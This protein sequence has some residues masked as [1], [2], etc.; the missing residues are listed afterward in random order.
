MAEYTGNGAKIKIQINSLPIR[1]SENIPVHSTP[2]ANYMKIFDKLPDDDLNIQELPIFLQTFRLTESTLAV[3]NPYYTF[4]CLDDNQELKFEFKL[5]IQ[6]WNTFGK[7]M[8]YYDSGGTVSSDPNITGTEGGSCNYENQPLTEL[9]N[10]LCDLDDI[11]STTDNSRC[12]SSSGYP[13][14]IYHLE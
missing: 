8:A 9:C 14:A 10:D 2:V 13:E 7:F 1:A 12:K 3:P 11:S 6:E 5:L 4:T